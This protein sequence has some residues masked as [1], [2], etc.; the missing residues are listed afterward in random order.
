MNYENKIL[1]ELHKWNKKAPLKKQYELENLKVK[2]RLISNGLGIIID[3]ILLNDITYISFKLTFRDCFEKLRKRI[4]RGLSRKLSIRLLD[5]V[6][7]S[8]LRFEAFIIIY[9][10]AV[11]FENDATRIGINSRSR[12]LLRALLLPIVYINIIYKDY[13]TEY[14]PTFNFVKN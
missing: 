3:S 14:S 7:I 11:T 12:S 1:N 10:S 9:L 5:C 2:Y 8:K 13:Y 4:N 6:K